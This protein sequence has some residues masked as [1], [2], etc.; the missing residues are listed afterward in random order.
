MGWSG[1]TFEDLD[2]LELAHTTTFSHEHR[3][4]FERLLEQAEDWGGDSGVTVSG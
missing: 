2:E 3:R 4:N 1:M